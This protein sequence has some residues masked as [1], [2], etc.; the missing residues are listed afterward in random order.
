MLQEDDVEEGPTQE[1]DWEEVT[2]ERPEEPGMDY[3]ISNDLI[4]GSGCFFANSF[5]DTIN[6]L[7]II[8]TLRPSVGNHVVEVKTNHCM[9]LS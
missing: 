6:L 5:L 4:E 7:R 2:E 8:Q 1:K 3:Y 9:G